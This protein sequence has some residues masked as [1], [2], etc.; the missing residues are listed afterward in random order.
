MSDTPT[1][2]MSQFKN[3]ELV[4]TAK[5]K[6]TVASGNPLSNASD[7]IKS[8]LEMEGRHQPYL[9]FEGGYY[10]RNSY[11]DSTSSFTV[12]CRMAKMKSVDDGNPWMKI[13]K[14]KKIPMEFK[15][16]CSGLLRITV[17]IEKGCDQA[18][19]HAK[20]MQYCALT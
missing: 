1:T 2:P 16:R 8:K 3:M 10:K 20:N 9:E 5:S 12:M 14:L 6:M 13:S 18:L 11:D 15:E 4:S 19:L 7:R 17:N